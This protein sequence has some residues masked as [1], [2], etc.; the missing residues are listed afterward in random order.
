M[1]YIKH[2]LKHL[3]FFFMNPK[4]TVKWFLEDLRK[5]FRSN[6]YKSTCYKVWCAGLP[7]SGTTLIEEIFENLPYVRLDNSILRLWNNQNLIHVHDLHNQAFKGFREQKYTFVKT[8]SHYLKEYENL[9]SSND[10]K[11]I[12]SFRDLRDVMISRYFHI[13]NDKNHWLHKRLLNLSFKEG[14]ILSITSKS[15]YKNLNNLHYYYFWILNWKK[16]AK[17]KGYLILWY[18]EYINNP[19]KY[20]NQILKYTSFLDIPSNKIINN[21]KKKKSNN[22]KESLY[23]FGKLKSTFRKGKKNQW[24]KY[25]DDEITEFFIKNLPDKLENVIYQNHLNKKN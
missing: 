7:K 8:H 18:E 23:N 14:F 5:D 11:L 3:R 6:K 9:I 20:I 22:L 19:K 17:K 10:V 13:M 25:F 4:F 12:I 2:F 15:G 24:M 16:I 21:L 1:K